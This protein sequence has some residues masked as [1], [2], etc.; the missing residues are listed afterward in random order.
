MA[1]YVD[2]S[3]WEEEVL[4]PDT[5]TPVLG[6]QPVWEGDRLV[7]GFY[8]VPIAILAD[9][10]RSLKD[11][12]E[13]VEN[14]V[15]EGLEGFLVAD[16]NLSDLED[17]GQAKYN[18]GLNLVDNTSDI[19]KPISTP[20]QTALDQKVDKESGKGLS[21]ND[22]TDADKE[23][24]DGI[25]PEATKNATD[26]QLR[27]RAT[28]T[29]EQ[30]I[31]SVTGLQTALNS[32][33][34][35]VPGKG[36]SSEDFT[37]ADKTKLS[38]IQEGATANQTD[39]YLLNRVNH[40]GTQAISTV[41]GLQTALDTK[42]DKVAGKQLSTEDFTSAEKT[43]LSGIESGATANQTNAFLVNRVNHTGTQAISTV[44]GLQGA[45]DSKV[46]KAAGMGLSQ[47][48]FT[49]AEKN[50]LALLEESHFKGLFPSLAALEAAVP[51]PVPGDY[52]QVAGVN[53]GDP[54]VTYV[55]DEPLNDWVV[56]VPEISAAQVKSLYESNPDTNAFTDGE[57]SKLAGIA[58]GATDNTGTV[59][60]V[61]ISVP[62]GLTV[63]GSPITSSGTLGITFTTGYSI[64]TNAK[65]T[66][67][68]AAYGWGNHASAGYATTSALTAGLSGKLDVGATATSANQLATARTINGTSFNGTAN[69][70]TA[71]WG[72]AR[73]LTV[74]ETGKSVNGSSNVTWSLVEIGAAPTVHTHTASQISDSTAVGRS[75]LTAADAAAART[76]IGAGT[77][78]LVI[79]TT[80]TTAKAGNYSPTSATKTNVLQGS[81]STVFVTPSS[82]FSAISWANG[83]HSTGT[84]TLNLDTSLNHNLSVG[85]NITMAVPSN[86]DPGKTGDI[87]ITMTANGAVSWASN[88]KFLNTLPDIGESGE[89]WVV[90]YKVLDSSTIIASASKVAT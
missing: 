15:I 88:W 25:S 20:T 42:V 58:D 19:N 70:T 9:R 59:T 41:S 45:L 48:S 4:I 63:S 23:K 69:I 82:Y 56:Q 79:G 64:P 24:L 78:D 80:S 61:G 36:L 11:R 76:V 54:S 89:M 73:T 2:K 34:D 18:L 62:T 30:P 44:S 10:T 5:N 14:E 57:K 27:D 77:S 67:W 8:N 38:G 21:E 22:F 31:S 26:A 85:G 43:K 74:G 90:S 28:H 37:A 12:I 33:V 84:V 39:S 87:V 52:A 65:Q 16:E 13:G 49:T 46:D 32:K 83:T 55:W 17:I 71:N 60:S 68:D 51:S 86:M 66:Q 3:F 47:E 29:G 53:P 75:V 81:S 7:D 6:G 50:K 40:T 1:R 72:T 35:V